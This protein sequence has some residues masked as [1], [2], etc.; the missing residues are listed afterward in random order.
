M[1]FFQQNSRLQD[2]LG[3]DYLSAKQAQLD[4][5]RQHILIDLID[6]DLVIIFLGGIG[7]Y[8][9]ARRTLKPIA[10]AHE[11]QVRFTADASHELRTPIAAMQTEIEVALRDKQITHAEATSLLKSNLEELAKLSGLAQGLLQLT[12][13]DS[14]IP[15]K[16]INMIDVITT[17]VER[18]T[19]AATQKEITITHHAQPEISILGDQQSLVTLV[20]TLL[21]N[22]IK[23]SPAKS[24]IQVKAKAIGSEAVLIV[25]DEGPGI[26]SIDLPHIFDRFYRASSNS[27]EKIDGYGLGLSI[28]KNIAERHQGRIEV[29]SE[30]GK[31]SVFT[32]RLPLVK[33]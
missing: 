20:V 2:F 13:E 18:V 23:Y 31:G 1:M 25:Q 26:K 10:E 28:A 14:A 12:R 3:D 11:A 27:K 29:K 30:L 5:G 9:L 22:A 7:S 6:V 4:E 33:A 15:T 17:A 24:N 16:P 21:D 19:K 32:V 8:F